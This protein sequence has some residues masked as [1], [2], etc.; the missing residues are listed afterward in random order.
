MLARQQ[1]AC[2]AELTAEAGAWQAL[3]RARANDYAMTEQCAHPYDLARTQPCRAI[4]PVRCRSCTAHTRP[5][6]LQYP[7]SMGSEEAPAAPRNKL[8]EQAT[9]KVGFS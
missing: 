5:A 4:A 7:A 2:T 3:A 9:A 8:E 1:G 6:I